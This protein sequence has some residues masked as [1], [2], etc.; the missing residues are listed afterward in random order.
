M[1][2]IKNSFKSRIKNLMARNKQ[3]DSQIKDDDSTAEKSALKDE[4]DKNNDELRQVRCQ[5]FQQEQ[6]NEDVAYIKQCCQY[7]QRLPLFSIC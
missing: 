1:D 4:K 5:R 2:S 6:F 7:L 3:L